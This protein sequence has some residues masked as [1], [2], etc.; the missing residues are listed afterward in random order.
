MRNLTLIILILSTQY[1]VLGQAGYFQQE[2]NTEISVLL[3]DKNNTLTGKEKITYQ[4]NSPSTLDSIVIH[5]WPNAYKNVDTELA[6]QKYESGSTIIKYASLNERGY[7]DSL[8]F[9]I[10]GKPVK[11]NYYNKHID[12]AIL[13]LNKALKTNEK[14]VIETPFFVKIPSGKFSRSKCNLSSA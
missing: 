9:K 12:V 13:H 4:N 5:L 1:L 14:I 11:W 10:D 2:V 8:A 6:K 7:I 3:N